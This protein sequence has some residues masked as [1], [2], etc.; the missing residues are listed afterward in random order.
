MLTIQPTVGRWQKYSFYL[1][2][3]FVISHLSS[4]VGLKQTRLSLAHSV[5]IWADLRSVNQKAL[6]FQSF[7]FD[8]VVSTKLKKLNI[9]FSF[10]RIIY[11]KS[12]H[13]LHRVLSPLD[14]VQSFAAMPEQKESQKVIVPFFFPAS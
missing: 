9:F 6:W 12:R 14:E 7:I 5:L 3:E 4:L 13:S 2:C 10:N 8:R 11:R 1:L